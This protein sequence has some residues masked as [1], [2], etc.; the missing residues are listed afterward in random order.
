M[1]GILPITREAI[2][3]AA[4]ITGMF[5]LD[6]FT[7]ITGI[8]G[9]GVIGILAMITRSYALSAGVIVLWVMGV[10]LKPIRDIFVGLPRLV[11]TLLSESPTIG[12]IVSQ[13]VVAFGALLLFLFIVEILLGRDIT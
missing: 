6:I 8:V 2:V 4:D 10:V 11:N 7:V 13:V 1:S 12:T 5:S 9:G 3:D